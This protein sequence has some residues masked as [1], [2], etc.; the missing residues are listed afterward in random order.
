MPSSV[1]MVIVVTECD[2]HVC[3]PGNTGV[4][5]LLINGV[6]HFILQRWSLLPS[7]CC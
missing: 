7:A 3:W 5:S 4:Y 1:G 6:V 2:V